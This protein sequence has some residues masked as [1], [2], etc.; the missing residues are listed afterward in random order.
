VIRVG[1]QV[2]MDLVMFVKDSGF[3]FFVLCMAFGF[4]ACKGNDSISRIDCFT[5]FVCF[6]FSLYTVICLNSLNKFHCRYLRFPMLLWP[7]S[8]PCLH[9]TTSAPPP[10]LAP[11]HACLNCLLIGVKQSGVLNTG[12]VRVDAC[13]AL[14][15]QH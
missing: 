14:W 5:C 11:C 12:L 4:S 9:C 1:N 10:L 7:Y 15:T 2:I 3:V 6:L 13:T 8:C